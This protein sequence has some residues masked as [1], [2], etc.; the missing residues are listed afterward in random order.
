MVELKDMWQRIVKEKEPCFNRSMV[1]LKAGEVTLFDYASGGF[2]RSMVE[3]KDYTTS[4]YKH[5]KN[6]FNRSMVE[7]KASLIFPLR[8]ADHSFNRSM[9]ELKE[10]SGGR[11]VI[12][13]FM[14]QSVY[15]RIESK[16]QSGP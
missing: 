16:Y 14:F 9:V 5:S 11:S 8:H 12:F 1:E 7:L 15:G 2:N 4:N 10:T 6:C 13:T 3:L